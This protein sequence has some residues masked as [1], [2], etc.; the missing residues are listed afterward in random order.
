ML[1][2]RSSVGD[3]FVAAGEHHDLGQRLVESRVQSGGKVASQ[4]LEILLRQIR[5]A[6]SAFEERTRD[7]GWQQVHVPCRHDYC[8]R[9]Q[10]HPLSFDEFEEVPEIVEAGQEGR[11]SARLRALPRVLVIVVV[12][13]KR[14]ASQAFAR[15][16][17]L[18]TLSVLWSVLDECV[19]EATD[20]DGARRLHL[21]S[22][23]AER[24]VRAL[25]LASQWLR[26]D[27]PRRDMDARGCALFD[28]TLS[29][30]VSSTLARSRGRT[31]F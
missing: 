27:G 6:V 8:G 15:H 11:T 7:L 2:P 16:K 12:V 24:L 22:V 9:S 1:Q 14:R 25:A 18:Q 29:L 5:E 23:W 26:R 17:T 20:T 13:L 3:A 30:V 21:C 4:C 31:V 10:G 19:D 28:C